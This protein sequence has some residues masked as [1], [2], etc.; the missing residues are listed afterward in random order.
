MVLQALIN[1][2]IELPGAKIQIIKN[3]FFLFLFWK[4]NFEKCMIIGK[5]RLNSPVKTNKLKIYGAF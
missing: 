5:N 3:D 1:L 4:V 2:I